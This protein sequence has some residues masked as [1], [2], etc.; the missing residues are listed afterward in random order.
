MS[1]IRKQYI[2]KSQAEI[3]CILKDNGVDYYMTPC[4]YG[5]DNKYAGS[6]I[7][8]FTEPQIRFQFDKHDKCNAI[9][10]Y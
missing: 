10:D 8:T 5:E 2:G 7:T 4:I 9:L 1:D 3:R 6:F